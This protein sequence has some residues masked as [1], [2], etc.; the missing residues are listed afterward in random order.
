MPRLTEADL[1]FGSD[2]FE[3]LFDN[4]YDGAY[5]V[6]RQRRLLYW[7]KGAELLTGY[8][9]AEVIGSYCHAHI[10]DHVDAQGRHLCMTDCPLV[11][12]MQCGLPVCDRV[13]LLHKDGRRI[14]VD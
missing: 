3:R 11:K 1:P 7:N 8:L 2:F 14:A 6:D 13:Y 10:L 9:S 12:T 4:L 5:F